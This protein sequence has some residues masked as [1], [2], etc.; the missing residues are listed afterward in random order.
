MNTAPLSAAAS[1]LSALLHQ[2][3]SA[4]LATPYPDLHNRVE[5]LQSLKSALLRFK[6]ALI[7]ALSQD[8]VHRSEDD[9]LIADIVPVI[10]N[11]NYTLKNLKNWLKPSARHAG[12]LLAPAKVCVHYQPLGVIG[13]IV[14]WNFPVMLSMGPLVT[15]IAAGNR[16]MLKMSEF[17]PA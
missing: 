6:T 1:P 4:Y 17:T 11:I 14:P 13:I 9:S 10:N 12:S 8:Y 3:R 15:A 5:Q 16:A 7:N 2:Q